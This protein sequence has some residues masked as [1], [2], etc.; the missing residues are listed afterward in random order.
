MTRY[1][2]IA[3][4]FT[5]LVTGILIA[6]CATSRSPASNDTAAVSKGGSQ[7]WAEN[8][9][10]CHN[11]RSPA[12]Y[13]DAQWEVIMQHMRVRANLTAEDSKLIEQFLKAGN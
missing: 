11:M 6:A 7:L 3:L 12:S 5:L 8:C 13:S 1:R 10:R 4:L 2:M 9:I